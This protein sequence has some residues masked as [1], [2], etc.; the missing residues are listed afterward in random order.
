M[1][2]R[3]ESIPGKHKTTSHSRASPSLADRQPVPSRAK[4][5]LSRA[6]PSA[7]LVFFSLRTV[8]ENATPR[9]GLSSIVFISAQGRKIILLL[10]II[11]RRSSASY[12][13][14]PVTP[15]LCLAIQIK[16]FSNATSVEAPRDLF[17]AKCSPEEAP[18]EEKNN[19]R[20]NTG[21]G[22]VLLE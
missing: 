19:D 11:R 3:C 13:S 20:R 9:R 17:V 22:T 21:H 14:A 1:M 8:T 18:E 6:A 2:V 16:L 4:I 7:L 15:T 5:V 12:Y 10:G